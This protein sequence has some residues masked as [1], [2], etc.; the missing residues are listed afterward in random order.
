MRKALFIMLVIGLLIPSCRKES[1]LNIKPIDFGK[2]SYD[3]R[4]ITNSVNNNN[5]AV[6]TLG[7]TPGSKYSVQITDI[8]GESVA[9]KGLIADEMVEI[10]TIDTKDLKNGVYDVVVIDINGKEIKQP[11]NIK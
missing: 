10:V 5:N 7:V 8:T 3:L 6:I 4:F 1:S 9:S 2:T 11:I